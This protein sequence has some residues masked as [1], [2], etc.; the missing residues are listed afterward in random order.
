VEPVQSPNNLSTACLDGHWK[1][2]FTGFW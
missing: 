2:Q 1:N